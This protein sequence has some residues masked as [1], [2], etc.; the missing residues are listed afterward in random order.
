MAAVQ[1]SVLQFRAGVGCRRAW[2]NPRADRETKLNDLRA[3]QPPGRA[4]RLEELPGPLDSPALS[5]PAAEPS[6]AGSASR[7][8]ARAADGSLDGSMDDSGAT[9]APVAAPVAPRQCASCAPFGMRGAR[10]APSGQLSTV[11]AGC[12]DCSP[13][14]APPASGRAATA[15]LAARP[16]NWCSRAARSAPVRSSRIRLRPGL[17]PSAVGRRA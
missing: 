4:E 10:A 9:A 12:G 6:A 1:W 16:G 17:S 14:A 2:D 15:T 5:P 11:P 7:P 3:A 13:S 8:R